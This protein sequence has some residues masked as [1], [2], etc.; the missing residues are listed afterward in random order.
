[1]NKRF[2]IVL[3]ILIALMGA[4]AMSSQPAFASSHDAKPSIVRFTV[5]NDTQYTFTMVMFGPEDFTVR[6]DPRSTK[7]FQLTRGM[8]SYVMNSCNF[9]ATGSIDLTVVQT[10]NVPVCGGNANAIASHPHQLD[11]S[12]V[13]K[14]IEITI[15]NKT[16]EDVNLYLRTLEYDYFLSFGFNETKTLYVLRDEY[17]YSF[18]ACGDLEAGKYEA[19]FRK[20]LILTCTEK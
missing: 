13:I 3:I 17:T 11:A 14:V 18:V 9:R 1:M 10:M 2:A 8:Y 7:A 15:K 6:V 4:A 12:D 19:R 16:K 5:D 20:P